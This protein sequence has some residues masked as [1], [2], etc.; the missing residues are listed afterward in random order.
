[1]V[2]PMLP[3]LI[4][5]PG[6]AH[7][8]AVEALLRNGADPNRAN[9]DGAP[10]L[11]NAVLCESEEMASSLVRHGANPNKISKLTHETPL[12]LAARQG[13]RVAVLF[14]GRSLEFQYYA[15]GEITCCHVATRAGL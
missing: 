3:S 11:H 10:A 9:D 5:G 6:H 1:M 12:W 7:Q 13:S 2:D 14:G 4:G 8:G 15:D